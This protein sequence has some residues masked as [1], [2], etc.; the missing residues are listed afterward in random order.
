MFHRRYLLQQEFLT[1]GISNS[2]KIVLWYLFF[3]TFFEIFFPSF[4]ARGCGDFKNW[5]WF[6]SFVK[7]VSI[8]EWKWFFANFS[9]SFDFESMFFLK[10]VAIF[11]F[12]LE[13]WSIVV[14]TKTYFQKSQ[15]RIYGHFSV[16]CCI[17]VEVLRK[18]NKITTKMVSPS[19]NWI[20]NKKFWTFSWWYASFITKCQSLGECLPLFY[21]LFG[22]NL[23]VCYRP[24]KKRKSKI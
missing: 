21:V 1:I 5:N 10:N 23:V 6:K 19:R 12:D 20:T 7:M 3:L 4:L 11:C 14:W 13:L 2:N 17:S 8:I 15:R 16:V 24:T 9:Y 18:M 22:W